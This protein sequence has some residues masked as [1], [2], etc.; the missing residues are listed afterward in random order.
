MRYENQLNQF[1]IF[2]FSNFA[3]TESC[4]FNPSKPHMNV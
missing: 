2:Q 3:I 4:N 1:V